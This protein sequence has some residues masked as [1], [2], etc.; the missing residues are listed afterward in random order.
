[1]GASS[2]NGI[3][4]SAKA[5]EQARLKYG[6]DAR[7]GDPLNIPLPDVILRKEPALAKQVNPLEIHLNNSLS[8]ENPVYYAGVAHVK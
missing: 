8:A 7:P 1:V 2:V 3:D 6:V 5:C 4:V